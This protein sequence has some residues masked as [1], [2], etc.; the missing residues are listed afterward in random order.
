MRNRLVKIVAGLAALP[1]LSFGGAA[2]ATAGG[3]G[4][5][6][7]P[8]KAPASQQAERGGEAADTDDLQI[9]N[10]EDDATEAGESEEPARGEPGT[11]LSGDD[12]PG[13]R[14]DEPANPNADHQFEG[15]E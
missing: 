13:G 15:Q 4:S 8:A 10:G 6:A 2:L 12:G 14:A 5:G 1:A 9:E 3:N 7:P 11:E